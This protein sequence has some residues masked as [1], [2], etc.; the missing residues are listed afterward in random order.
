MVLWQLNDPSPHVFCHSACFIK[1]SDNVQ[2][3]ISRGQCSHIKEYQ[4]CSIMATLKS[5]TEELKITVLAR[6]NESN[7]NIVHIQHSGNHDHVYALI[8][9]AVSCADVLH[10]HTVLVHLNILQHQFTVFTAF[11]QTH[12]VSYVHRARYI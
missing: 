12:T 8:L 4:E 9:T 11:P 3:E 1:T 6:A 2:K 10:S 7:A 5:R